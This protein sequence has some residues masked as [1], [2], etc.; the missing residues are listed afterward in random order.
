M[1]HDT[2]KSKENGERLD[3]LSL[4]IGF[5]AFLIFRPPTPGGIAFFIA[6][7]E[8][9]LT[10]IAAIATPVAF[11][12]FARFAPGLGVDVVAHSAVMPFLL[13]Q[14]GIGAQSSGIGVSEG[15]TGHLYASAVLF[16][17]QTAPQAGALEPA[18]IRLGDVLVDR[19][20]RLAA[21]LSSQS[22]DVIVRAMR[23]FANEERSRASRALRTL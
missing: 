16:G 21:D 17:A 3:N 22:R 5:V 23:S 15:T 9:T 1:Q 4:D 2:A 7:I 11:A 19:A 6:T 12:F 8:K 20:D 18:A 10:I 14:A 13:M